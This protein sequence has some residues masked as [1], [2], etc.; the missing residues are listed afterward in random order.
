MSSTS[1]M[2]EWRCML[3][4]EARLAK[5]Q[6][7]KQLEIRVQHLE[8]YEKQMMQFEKRLQSIEMELVIS[9]LAQLQ[10]NEN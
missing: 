3:K 2:V 7:E 1:C 4:E 6:Y 9:K 10:L 5:L 8:Q